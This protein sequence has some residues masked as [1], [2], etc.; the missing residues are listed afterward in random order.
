VSAAGGAARVRAVLAARD[1]R[2][3]L[4]ARVTSQVADGMFTSAALLI[5]VFLPEQQS[6][7][8][9]FAVATVVF[10]LPFS[11][12]GL[13]A[14]VFVDRWRRRRIL[15]AVP[16]IRAAAAL[17]TLPGTAAIPL[18]YAGTLTVLSA[19][20]LYQAT[21]TAVV[22]R[23]LGGPSP[24]E[25]EAGQTTG[26]SPLF[27][28]NTIAAVAGTVALFGGMFAGGQ[29]AVAAGVP[30]VL[31]VACV[32]WLASSLLGASL[33]SSLTPERP[34]ARLVGELAAVLAELRAGLHRIRTTPEALAPILAV[35][36]G[37]FLQ[38]IVIV[39]SLL[40]VKEGLGGGLVSFSWLVAAGG[41][42]VFLGFV[43]V[44]P[45]RRWLPERL[46]IG[47]AFA[48]GAASLLPAIVALSAATLSVGA[49]L[50][51]TSYGWTRVPADTL[52]QRA[53]PDRYRGRVFT[54]MDLGF[55]LARVLGAL[56]S[57]PL[58]PRLGP[59]A[60]LAVISLLLL[61]WAPVTP[62]WLRRSEGRAR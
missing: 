31:A 53:V 22:P 30:A 27:L 49:V 45:L 61:L 10:L 1:F 29:L 14:G 3:L 58:V 62:L 48:L 8:R 17:L 25:Y 36:V 12:I 13:Y 50:L 44:G 2:R 57:I 5:M 33:S 43:S 41:A 19:A 47:V 32:A 39:V 54:V 28:A 35:A 40:V 7:V 24:D 59:Q 34:A 4:A 38:M 15:V 55:N 42:G 9:D 23:V 26:G 51:G 52:A 20:R 37:Q 56:V 60:T 21:S 16:V 18:V 11:L 46:L 6:T